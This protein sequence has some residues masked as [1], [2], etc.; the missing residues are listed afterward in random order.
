MRAKL[1]TLLILVI[2]S[3]SVSAKMIKLRTNQIVSF[4]NIYNKK[5]LIVMKNNKV[6]ELYNLGQFKAVTA[7]CLERT[8]FF[9]KVK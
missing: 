8:E 6:Y 3:M 5:F 1:F 9:V 4:E 7:L 2:F